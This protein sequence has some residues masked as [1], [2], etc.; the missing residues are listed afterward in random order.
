M[1][2]NNSAIL[3]NYLW[4]VSFIVANGAF[5]AGFFNASTKSGAASVDASSEKRF[6]ILTCLGGD[7]NTSAIISDLFSVTNTL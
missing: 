1:M 5:G 4:C 7:S 2:L 3:I 6:V